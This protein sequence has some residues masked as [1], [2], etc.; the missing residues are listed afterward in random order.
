MSFG[1]V[2]AGASKTVSATA[3]NS[4]SA[5][6]MINSL[7]FST[8]YF[9]LA[10]P[11]LPIAIDAGKSAPIS[12]TFAP[13]AAGTFNASVAIASDASDASVNMSLAGNGTVDAPPLTQLVVNPTSLGVGSVLVGSSGSASGTLIASGG[14]VTV[15]AGT[16]DNGAFT[17]SEIAFPI[18]IPDGQ[19]VPFSV[20]FTPQSAGAASA[21]LTFTSDAEPSTTNESVTGT[22]TAVTTVGQLGS[23][24]AT[25]AVGN[26]VVG[27]SGS[28]SG[29]LSATGANVT[30]TD[31]T[32]NNSAFIL[33]GISLPL[34]IPAGQSVLFSVTFS[35]TI[36]GNANATLTF[37]SNA[38][39]S[40]TTEAVTGSGTAAPIHYVS[41]SWTSS[42]S[43]NI[44]G[45][46]VYRASYTTTC[47]SFA[48]IN[49]LLNT[50]TL[51]TDSTVASGATYCYATTAVNT[52]NLE[53]GYSNIVSNLQIP[54]P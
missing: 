13:N 16:S 45:Y 30:V 2:A 15:T 26:V 23:R 38:Q 53:S 18:T 39:P 48:K 20:T 17:V 37:T 3:T 11:V 7:S 29:T 47:G 51:Y 9:S 5:T 6:L 22:G 27:S 34:T 33:N 49:S 12:I 8:K 19:S 24:P 28:G 21:T 10:S 43:G 46:N 32:S 40:T 41:L 52:S 35:P 31:A 42:T 1:S 14:S 44:S 25:I 54:T 36:T 50:S 4:G